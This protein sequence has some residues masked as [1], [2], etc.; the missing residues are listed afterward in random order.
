[1]NFDLIAEYGDDIYDEE[2]EDKLISAVLRRCEEIADAGD[3]EGLLTYSVREFMSKESK[4]QEALMNQ[5]ED[6]EGEVI[7]ITGEARSADQEEIPE[8]YKNMSQREAEE[9]LKQIE[10]DLSHP[11]HNPGPAQ[12]DYWARVISCL[13]EKA[14]AFG[15]S[16]TV[17]PLPPERR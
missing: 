11:W 7:L 4:R 6:I 8:I 14:Y 2:N 13:Q 10:A 15:E 12:K 1:M 16:Y 3:P 9:E 5:E 17:D